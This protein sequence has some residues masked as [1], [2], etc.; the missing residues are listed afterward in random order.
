MKEL[1]LEGVRTNLPKVSA[2][3]NDLPVRFFPLETNSASITVTR[4]WTR[5]PASKRRWPG[6]VSM[7]SSSLAG[8]TLSMKAKL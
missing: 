7:R 6:I 5:K 2:A 4:F 3:E 8:Q 1:V